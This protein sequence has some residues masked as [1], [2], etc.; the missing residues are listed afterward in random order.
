VAN[1]PEPCGA[2]HS[3]RL[4]GQEL[5][6]QLGQQV[7]VENRGG[8]GGTLGA[9]AAARSAPDGL[10]LLLT[11]NSLAMSVGLYPALP[12][13]P[14]TDLVQVS[15]IADSPS[16]LLVRPGLGPRDVQ[17]LVALAKARPGALSFGSGGQGSSAH[18]AMELLLNVTDTQ[19]LHI[20]FR[21]VAAAIAEVIAGRVDMA[22]ASLA[23]GVA[24][25]RAGTLLGLGV[26]GDARAAALPGV[27]TFIEAGVPRYDMT[28]WW[29][30]AAP[31]GTPP[32]IIARL[33][34]EVG[35]AL[36]KPRLVEAFAAQGATPVH[37]TPEA[38]AAHLAREVTLWRAVIARAGVK[39]E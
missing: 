26:T 5:T 16:I 12:Y 38:M 17:A 2:L 22:I 19:M 14:L 3:A 36:R 31:K 21:G 37:S 1:I 29:G 32:E 7:V 9:T 13:D 24:H 8:A 39:A 15:R 34:A 35:T 11:D 4:L 6:E 23:S 25:V 20:P 27:P 18:L 33:N 10:T 28:Y 30:L